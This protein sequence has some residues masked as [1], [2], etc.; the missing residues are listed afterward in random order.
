MKWLSL[1]ATSSL[2]AAPAAA[3]TIPSNS[4]MRE[5]TREH[6]GG[7]T[8]GYVEGERLEYRSNEGDP[9]FL[10]DAQ[11]WY[12]GD[13]NKLWVKTEGEYDFKADEF[14]EAEVQA[15]WSRAIGG[16]FDAQAGLRHDFAPGGDRTFAVVGLQGLTPYLFE[17]DSALF[18]SDDG[19]VSARI[20]A[21]YELLITQRLIL[22]P[23]TELNF[24]F[25]DVPEY[26][27]GSGLSTAEVGARLR[28]E[29]KR[30][31]APYIGVSW[32][33]ALGDTADFARADGEDPGGVS[34]L[35]GVRIW[36]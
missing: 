2:L 6:H 16:F 35:A 13:I 23:R 8:L 14:E 29:I 28:Y 18:V 17:V 30:E 9:V 4:E 22:Q 11:G 27:L 36:F 12:G 7:L 34:F 3:Q 21:E 33:R 31:F 15:L 26:G 5:H 1:L 19:D 24:E 25:Q 20:E 32:E 10:W